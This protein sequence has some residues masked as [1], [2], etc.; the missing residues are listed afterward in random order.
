MLQILIMFI[1]FK[2]FPTINIIF[3]QC[4][5]AIFFPI[6]LPPTVIEDRHAVTN[7]DTIK[8]SLNNNKTKEQFVYMK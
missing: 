5:I 6:A 2:I 3:S 4:L 1:L 8:L 7:T